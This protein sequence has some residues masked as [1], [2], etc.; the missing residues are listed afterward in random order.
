MLSLKCSQESSIILELKTVYIHAEHVVCLRTLLKTLEAGIEN[1]NRL[2]KNLS[3]LPGK[4]RRSFYAG[5]YFI[6]ILCT[7]TGSLSFP[8]VPIMASSFAFI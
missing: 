1:I 5:F 7:N 4:K 2:I 8:I 6:V 3:G